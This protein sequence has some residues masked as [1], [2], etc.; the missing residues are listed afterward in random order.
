[1][2]GISNKGQ[3]PDMIQIHGQSGGVHSFSQEE[4]TAFAE[5]INNSLAND[6]DLSYLLPIDT[7]GQQLASAVTDGVLLAKLINKAVADTIDE[8]ALNKRRDGKPLSLFQVN[9]N[10]NLAI[11]SAKAIGVQTVNLG[12]SELADGAA[13]PHLVL[14]LV[15][16]IVKLQLLNSI[17]LKNHPELIRLLEDGED[18]AALLRLPPDQL[19]LRWFNYHLKNAGHKG[20]VANF[21]SDVKDSIAYTVLLHQINASKCDNSALNDA[22]L[23]VR[24]GKVLRNA[25]N[26]DVHAF[27]TPGDIV[28]GNAR[29]NL[30]FTASIFNTCPGLDPLTEQE[31]MELAGM[32]D[33]D[34]GDSREERAFRMWINTL[35]IEGVYVNGLYEDCRDGLV[36]L[37]VID[38]VAPGTVDW[39]KVEMSPKNK[40]KKLSNCNYAVVLGKSLKFSL[41]GIGGA[42]IVDAN[43]KLLLALTWQLMRFHIISFLTGLGGGVRVS[44]D[45]IIAWANAQV[46]AAGKPSTMATFNDASLKTSQFFFDL[47]SAVEP[48]IINWDLVTPGDTDDDRLMNARYAI[49]VA[50]KLG[51]TIFLL[52][53]DIV[54]IKPK[55]IMTFTAGLMAVALSSPE[56]ASK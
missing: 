52:P 44:D 14:G 26:L 40:F 20:K 10:L 16:Q 48:R 9:E 3:S 33:D 24:A 12:A 23:H 5:H 49:S 35:G 18:L 51:A 7:T 19:L 43:R 38:H 2:V 29:L 36:L 47:L 37:R 50:R 42:D 11:A 46:K 22:D 21:S 17:N 30:A 34:F 6:A 1:M 15:W 32:M 54:E 13:H 28:R 4:M 45:A 8:R 55:M 25:T 31:A 41:V 27:I 53:E 56:T 39:T